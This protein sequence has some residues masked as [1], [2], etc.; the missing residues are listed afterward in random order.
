MSMEDDFMKKL[1]TGTIL[2]A[3]VGAAP[4]WADEEASERWSGAYVGVNLGASFLRDE[5]AATPML[6]QTPRASDQGGTGG[7]QLGWNIQNGNQ[8]S[9]RSGYT[10]LSRIVRSSSIKIMFSW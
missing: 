2:L 9:L 5:P 7:V 6:T 4:V 10:N 1:L 8:V 3:C